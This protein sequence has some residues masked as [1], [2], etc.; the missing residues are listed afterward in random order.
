MSLQITCKSNVN[1]NHRQGDYVKHKVRIENTGHDKIYKP[2]VQDNHGN[3]M[4]L[5]CRKILPKQ[6]MNFSFTQKLTKND[7][8]DDKYQTV[9]IVVGKTKKNKEVSS[10][11]VAIIPNKVNNT[12]K[13]K[14][15]SQDNSN[16]IT[17]DLKNA[18]NNTAS[19]S[20]IKND[21]LP[22]AAN[23]QPVSRGNAC[24][25]QDCSNVVPGT[26]G[27]NGLNFTPD[28][29]AVWTSLVAGI[30]CPGEAENNG[31][32]LKIPLYESGQQLS[33]ILGDI[34][35]FYDCKNENLYFYMRAGQNVL[36]DVETFTN[37][38]ATN[39]FVRDNCAVMGSGKIPFD[40]HAYFGL[41]SDGTSA[42]GFEAC[43]SLPSTDIL[44]NVEFHINSQG[45]TVS[46]GKD[47]NAICLKFSCNFVPNVSLRKSVTVCSCT[48]DTTVPT[49]VKGVNVTYNFTIENTGTETLQVTSLTDN[50]VP[51]PLSSTP[52]VIAPGKSSVQKLNMTLSV[53]GLVTDTARVNAIGLCTDNTIHTFSNTVAINVVAAP[54]VTLTKET[55]VN[56]KVLS[57]DCYNPDLVLVDSDVTWKY[58]I[59]NLSSNVDV[60]VLSLVDDKANLSEGSFVLARNQ[61]VEYMRVGKIQAGECY[62][63][64]AVLRYNYSLLVNGCSDKQNCTS[65]TIELSKT[66]CYCPA[67]PKI[68]IHKS[69]CCADSEGCSDDTEC[70][71]GRCDDDILLDVLANSIIKYHFRVTNTGNVPLVNVFIDDPATGCQYVIDTLDAGATEHRCCL[72]S[73]TETNTVAVIGEYTDSVGQT[74]SPMA[75]DTVCLNLVNPSYTAT[76]SCA[77]MGLTNPA[78]QANYYV[79]LSNTGNVDVNVDVKYSDTC[80]NIVS[81]GTFFVPVDNPVVFNLSPSENCIE[82]DGCDYHTVFDVFTKGSYDDD[83]CSKWEPAEVLSEGSCRVGVIINLTKYTNGSCNSG[84]IN[85]NIDIYE[86]SSYPPSGSPVASDVF[87]GNKCTSDFGGYLLDPE[88]SYVLVESAVPVTW[89]PDAN[90]NGLPIVAQG[91]PTD[92]SIQYFIFLPC[93]YLYTDNIAVNIFINNQRDYRQ[94]RTPGYWKNWSTCGNGNQVWVAQKNGGTANGFFLLNDLLPLCL[95]QCN[96]SC[97]LVYLND[98]GSECQSGTG[99]YNAVRILSNEDLSG[100]NRANDAAYNLAR[101]LTAV[102]LNLSAGTT[103]NNILTEA[104]ARAQTLLCQLGFDGV[105]AYLDPRSVKNNEVLQMLRDRALCLSGILDNYNNNL[106]LDGS[107]M[108]LLY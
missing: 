93:N 32:V 71:S 3:K 2:C 7:F 45:R 94:A 67:D 39:T 60:N 84:P 31:K 43:V 18:T 21:V 88:K 5:S 57:D 48:Y 11:E 69:V 72:G 37:G 73:P 55:I 92:N 104:M 28:D 10:N 41:S 54:N 6:V 99:V 15:Y 81:A 16:D 33:K 19:I 105:G 17:Q 47:A 61:M 77:S 86:G 64:T 46:S 66:N 96:G 49:V 82:A 68:E 95:Y 107:C 102:L 35:L 8:L 25:C 74:K 34:F 98:G 75:R 62:S 87:A 108:N 13:I 40:H 44:C 20:N 42:T 1:E 65:D 85:W 101:S 9:L 38:L 27:N 97:G 36:F 59:K 26:C 58:T 51:V 78:V 50:G 83:L 56:G 63:N 53:V 23:C 29:L 89:G 24:D 103:S 22:T 106:P 12:E 30:N 90:I 52:L 70:K 79:I 4:A 100:R 91:D 80:S 76:V 14:V